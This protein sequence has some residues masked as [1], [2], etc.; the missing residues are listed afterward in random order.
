MTI[1]ELITALEREAAKSS[2]GDD[3]LVFIDTT[4]V[5]REDLYQ[6]GSVEFQDDTAGDGAAI[7][8]MASEA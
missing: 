4:E 1:R 3:T 6:V 7:W 8:I 5:P 2:A